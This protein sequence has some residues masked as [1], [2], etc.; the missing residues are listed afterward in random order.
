MNIS[1][2]LGE[3]E[4]DYA[5]A[6]LGVE[7]FPY[8]KLSGKTIVVDGESEYMKLTVCMSLLALNDKEKLSIKVLMLGNG[9]ELSEKLAER[10][11]FSLCS[12]EQAAAT[13]YNF[14]ISTGICG[15]E[16]NG[17]SAEYCRITNNFARAISTAKSCLERCIL[18]SDYRVYGELESGLVISE[19]EAG[20]VPFSNNGDM[21]QT[22]AV[23]IETYFSAYAKQFN[24][25][26]IILR[27]GILLG[28]K[29]ELP[30]NFT[31]ELFSAVAEGKQIS[32]PNTR[33]K[34]SFTYLNEVIHALLYA[35]YEFKENS[36]FNVISRNA[37]VSV[38]MLASMIYD[39]YPEFAKIELAACEDDPY[40]G[41]AMN[42][43][44]IV[45]SNCEPL[46]E[47]SEIIQLCV[48]SRQTEEPFGYDASH[49]GKM[50]NI[51][52]VLVGYL[53][54]FD[55]ICRKHNIKYFLGG[56]TLLGAVRHEGFIPW[57]DDADIM[58]LREDYD[59]FLEIA[60]SE[61]PEGL[62]LQ[63]SKTDKYCHYP[64]AKIRLDDT[65]FATKYSKTHGKMNNGMAFDI[66]AHDN[67]ANSAL[68]QKLHL[69]FTLLIR[70]MIF[71]KWN[72]RK[73]NNK[74]KVQSFVANILKAIF[75]IRV[76]QWIQ[77]RI[78]K[79]FKHKK[80]A[81]YL[82]DGMGRN[83]YHG[84]FPKSYLDEVI[85]VKIHGHDFPIPKE[86][87]KYLTYLYGDYM[88]LPPAS[89]RQTSH[90]IV[91]LDMS[92]YSKFEVNK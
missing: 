6:M 7:D 83:V 24:L 60:Q 81:K 85:Y 29:A 26:T 33:K 15:L 47:L 76:S 79:I 58:M 14:F 75:P 78:F 51:Q 8:Q 66:F 34:Y 10:N 46:L 18:L 70:A 67:T 35:F 55:R 40:Y 45:N 3:Y 90:S 1:E 80:N 19:N 59:K 27:S 72:H 92:E 71:N 87:D 41:T 49:E 89:Q 21:S 31:D 28:A 53:L 57:D 9:N 48:K 42:N 61:L 17:T 30:K 84:A 32:L 38:G 12:Y 44:M 77:Y 63:T 4:R 5:L 13:E 73:I 16:L 54:E 69:Q 11:D 50:V 74:K 37:T 22:T 39:I 91:Q 56:G 88:K 2:M 68:G 25:P 86:Y 20:F 64:F 52:N 36:V 82:Y 43:A 65:M 62:T 23:S